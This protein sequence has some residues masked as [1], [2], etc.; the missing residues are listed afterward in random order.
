MK[1]WV[2][3]ISS[4]TRNA[5]LN[6]ELIVSDS[7]ISKEG[8]I[9]AGKVLNEKNTYN[10][11]EL[12]SGRMSK[13]CK[14]DVIVGVLGERHALRG[15][16]G[17]VPESLKVGDVIQILNLGGIVGTCVGGNAELG[18]P[19]DIEVLG[20][21]QRFP[22][23]EH[24]V[25]VPAHIMESPVEISNSLSSASPLIIVTG[26]CMS[27]GKTR[28]AC[29]M[30]KQLSRSGVRVGAAKLSG[31][32]LMRDTLEMADH[33]A[34][35]VLNFTDAGI[36]CSRP[37]N[38]LG[39]AKG[40]VAS[41]T[42][43]RPDCIVLEF[44]DGIMGEYGVM[45]LLSDTELMSYVAFHVLCAN[46]PVGAWGAQRFLAGKCPPID[47]ISGPAT[48]NEVGKRFVETQLEITAR[49]AITEGAD[50]GKLAHQRVRL[51]VEGL[52]EDSRVVPMNRFA[53][54]GQGLSF[55]SCE[56]KSLG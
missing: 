27:A 37:T 5:K 31:I 15:F 26:T 23:L 49:N 30:V 4:A 55:D 8:Y 28:A 11:L 41:L 35:A 47:V 1:L 54:R 48:D 52:R 25:G 38:V 42:R 56:V 34:C 22:S 17:K 20:A 9:I 39:A 53:S 40:I 50:L 43:H 24:R 7:I 32:S 13:L 51:F 3:K 14:G 16:S 46:D 10:T 12:V 29:E 45:T 19:I 2:D 33:G 21:V 44:G 36:A 18:K 6:R